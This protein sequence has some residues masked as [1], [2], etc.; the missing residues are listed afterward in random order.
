MLVRSLIW[1][2]C[3][4]QPVALSS[5]GKTP[6]RRKYNYVNRNYLLVCESFVASIEEAYKL[7]PDCVALYLEKFD[8]L[9][10]L[11]STHKSYIVK[12]GLYS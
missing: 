6:K 4:C 8:F 11:Y 5:G 12:V 7:L 10:P 1:V 9:A 3:S 2:K